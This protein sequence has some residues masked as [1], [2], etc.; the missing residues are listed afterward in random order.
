MSAPAFGP[1]LGSSLENRADVMFAAGAAVT[2]LVE[3]M[4][5]FRVEH[6]GDPITHA[7]DLVHFETS[8]VHR[9]WRLTGETEWIDGEVVA[10]RGVW[11]D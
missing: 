5:F 1:A 9:V 11:P 2:L 4:R 6:C 8:K 3:R 10:Y 7:G